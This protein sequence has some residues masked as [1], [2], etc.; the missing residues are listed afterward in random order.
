[1]RNQD[2]G[3]PTLE[4]A[5]QL[6]HALIAGVIEPIVG[7]VEDHQPRLPQQDAGNADALQQILGRIAAAGLNRC[8]P[9]MGQAR[10]AILDAQTVQQSRLVHRH[11]ATLEQRQ[12]VEQGAVETHRTLAGDANPATQ[13]GAIPDVERHA[14]EQDPALIRRHQPGDEID[15]RGLAHA[16]LAADAD[17][18]AGAD[19][20]AQIIK[21]R[22]TAALVGKPHG[23]QRELA[24]RL[25]AK[26]AALLGRQ[27]KAGL[28]TLPGDTHALILRPQ[29]E[30]LHHRL[31]SPAAEQGAR[32]HFAQSEL[33]RDHQP[34]CGGSH[35]NDMGLGEALADPAQ[36]R[37]ER[38]AAMDRWIDPVK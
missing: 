13:P 30:R 24:G 11:G 31:Q 3:D 14:I 27:A 1:M 7:V 34:G 6:D 12:I 26:R 5:Q 17:A 32:R 19:M 10:H 37:R 29:A 35:G 8:L 38:R 25:P 22:L 16:V 15:Q 28:Q 4:I 9:A 20:Q 33:V 21:Y 36:Q 18:F 2:D 23:L